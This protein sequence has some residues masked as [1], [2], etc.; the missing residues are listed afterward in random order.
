MTSISSRPYKDQRQGLGDVSVL[1]TEENPES[2]TGD[3][4]IAPSMG[5]GFG[6]DMLGMETGILGGYLPSNPA[7]PSQFMG[8]SPRAGA[9]NVRGRGG[10]GGAASAVKERPLKPLKRDEQ[11]EIVSFQPLTAYTLSLDSLTV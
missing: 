1:A 6:I 5:S 7:G 4:P 9:P 10:R 3:A 11:L 8:D 2:W